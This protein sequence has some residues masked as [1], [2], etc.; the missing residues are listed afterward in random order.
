MAVYQQEN[1]TISDRLAESV[2]SPGI[3]SAKF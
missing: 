3:L 1:K 2:D